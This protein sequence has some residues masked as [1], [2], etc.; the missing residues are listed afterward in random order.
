ITMLTLDS[1]VQEQPIKQYIVPYTDP[2]F[3]QAM[4]KWLV[5]TDQ[6]IQALEHPAFQNMMNIAAHAKD[7]VKI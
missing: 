7:G 2:V 3:C 4:I 6:P 1:Y 5:P